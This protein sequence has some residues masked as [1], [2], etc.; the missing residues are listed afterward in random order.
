MDISLKT[1]YSRKKGE[2]AMTQ[3][4]NRVKNNEIYVNR[5]LSW[6]K[7]NIRVLEEAE[8]E[9]VPL[10][11]RL[12]FVSI[13]SSNLDEFFMVRVGS[14]YDQ[15]LIKQ[16]VYENKTHMTA[17]EQIDAICDTVKE[18]LPRKDNVYSVIQAELSKCGVKQLN[19]T[20]LT[21]DEYHYLH[22][23]F[24]DEILPLVS[25][26][27]I[28]KHH[29]FPFLKNKEIYVG[30]HIENKGDTVKVGIIPASGMFKRVI[31]VP[32]SNE[33]KFVLVEDVISFFADRIFRNCKILDKTIFR[34]TRNA[35]VTVEEGLYDHDI[36]YR[37]IM[38]DVLKKRKKLA[39]VRLELYRSDNVRLMQYLC[40]K[41]QLAQRAVFLTAT[42]LDL[43]FVYGLE[44]Y[45]PREL[46]E[47]LSFSPLVPQQSAQINPSEP[48]IPQIL[49]GDILLHYPYENIGDFI[50]LLEESA[51]DPEVVSI[52]ITL[53]R[54]A[55][56][57]KVI[58][59][60][61]KAA[62]NGKDVLVMVE[63]RARFDEE[64]NIDWSKQLEEA[65]CSVIYGLDEYKVHSKLLLI[66]RR[67][68]NKISY[69][70]QIGTGNYN[71]KT[72]KLYTD[73]SLLTANQDIGVD[74]SVVF[75]NLSIGNKTEYVQNL[76]VAPLCLKSRIIEMI[77]GEIAEARS[78]NKA[79][80][81]LKMNSLS[82]KTLIDKLVEASKNGV[83][84]EML[85]RGICC[86]KAGIP[87]QTENITIK[88][89]V[90]RYL[91]HSRIYI[92]GTG[93]RQKIFISSADFMT[94]NTE[95]RVEVAT[96]IFS[97]AEKEKIL[98]I[99]E[100][101]RSDN[102]KTRIQ[103]PSGEYRHLHLKE[104]ER[105]IDSQIEFYR[106]AYAAAK[107]TRR[108]TSETK[109]NSIPFLEK[110]KKTLFKK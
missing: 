28:D 38:T 3:E 6:L 29:P 89:I 102:V 39:P 52:K 18:I 54:V 31:Y 64:N 42:P 84:V 67:S 23:Y 91:E 105:K 78:G 62:E 20:A 11:E 22:R 14:L 55:N 77:D 90:G 92:F 74:A 97:P 15:S 93:S 104:G 40:K 85:I 25:P 9:A 75:T 58:N 100:V 12:K 17:E 37:T 65:G 4:E 87:G 88:S 69:I 32:G 16:P 109:K 49:R 70:T 7:F 51:V 96:P 27:I 56:D 60:L 66:T 108:A 103:L 76:L 8:D 99:V 110:I 24:E 13:F 21:E 98:K 107:A 61:I 73:L 48:M 41:L 81:F 10:F 47:K 19:M 43:S 63:L 106:Q 83:K 53:Y 71:E 68:H 1:Q 57:S 45:F 30:V 59:A 72:S 50:R 2:P 101:L 34:I 36:D 5:E 46:K 94:R 35:D 33:V 82:D 26:Q 80:I 86:M 95:R 44:S 79:W